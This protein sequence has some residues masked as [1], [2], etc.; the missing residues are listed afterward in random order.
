M[1]ID[2]FILVME[3]AGYGILDEKTKIKIDKGVKEA[4]NFI[5]E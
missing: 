1:I 4:L 2:N 5:T 3:I